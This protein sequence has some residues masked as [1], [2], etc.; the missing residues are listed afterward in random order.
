[1]KQSEELAEKEKLHDERSTQLIKQEADLKERLE[2]L[3]AKEKEL[4]KIAEQ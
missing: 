3:E 2:K 4:A 1:M